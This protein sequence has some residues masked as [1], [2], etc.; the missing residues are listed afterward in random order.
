MRNAWKL[1][2]AGSMPER[3]GGHDR[4]DDA[5]E[6][7]GGLDRRFG[8]GRDDGAGDAAGEPLLAELIEDVGERAFLERVHEIR[9]GRPA[10]VHAHVERAIGR[11]S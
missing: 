2:V 7:R 8:A 11:E 4:A 3:S 10:A 9:R 5:R 6:L 1:R